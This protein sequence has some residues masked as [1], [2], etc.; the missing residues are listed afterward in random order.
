MSNSQGWTYA[1]A[2]VDLSKHRKMHMSAHELILRLSQETGVEVQ[3]LDEY[4]PYVKIGDLEVCLHVDGVGT[5]TLILDRLNRLNVAGWDAVAMNVNDI[6]CDGFKPYVASLYVSLPESNEEKFSQ[7]MQGVYEAA[8]FSKICIVGGETAIMP[9]LVT[10]P[11]V[12]C[13]LIGLRMHR[14]VTPSIGDVLVGVE[15][16]GVHANG[17]TLIRKAILTKYSL[18]EY[19]PELGTT[20]GEELSRPT[21]IYSNLTLELYEKELIKCAAHITGGAFTK[22]RRILRKV[23]RGADIVLDS[24]P[25]PKPIFRFV[26][27]EANVSLEEM[28]RVF[29]MG[30]GMV[31]VTSREHVD[32]VVKTCRRHGFNA[33]VIGRISEGEGRVK[34]VTREGSIAY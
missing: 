19:I 8:R 12:C 10:G 33:Y 23:G 28:Y 27:R 15:S 30:I 6:V 16:N 32:E 3:G 21:Y 29:N 18:D 17:Y 22:L 13:F 14:P 2:G 11:D 20:L 26:Q 7:I 5:K 9:D 31:Y 4:A 24:L 25:E 34:I 1:K